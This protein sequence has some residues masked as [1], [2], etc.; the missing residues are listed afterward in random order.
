MI[1]C[2]TLFKSALRAT[3]KLTSVATL[4]A[5]LFAGLPLSNAFAQANLDQ[6][7]TAAKAEGEVVFYLAPTEPIAKALVDAFTARY[8]IKASFLR[9]STTPLLQRFSA[10]ADSN[11]T[12]ADVLWLSGSAEQNGTFGNDA[13]KRGW[14]EPVARAGLPVLQGGRFP[15]RFLKENSAVT[16]FGMWIIGFNT[17]RIKPNEVPRTWK[18]LLDPRFAN[19]VIISDPLISDAYLPFWG[20]LFESYGEDFFA[21]LRA[22]K[23]RVM[24]SAVPATQALAAG[25]ATLV[26]PTVHALISSL[27]AKGAPIEALTPDVTTSTESE[28]FLVARSRSKH[29]NAGRL[30]VNFM[31]SEEGS[32][33]INGV[34]GGVE[35]VY[36]TRALPSGYKSPRMNIDPTTLKRLLGL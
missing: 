12:G 23:P 20:L 15:A 18:E 1:D 5:A 21:R 3:L 4:V 10:E 14:I 17:S 29:P 36:N 35:S 8:G 13:A 30:L 25:E 24:S 22:L 7:V 28:V 27:K 33:A 34:S 26:I 19:Q 11:N 31:L 16:E 32:K 9:L 2:R 6:L